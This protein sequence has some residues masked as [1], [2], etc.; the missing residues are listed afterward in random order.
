MSSYYANNT[1]KKS[2]LLK[3]C[4]YLISILQKCIFLKLLCNN[5]KLWERCRNAMFVVEQRCIYIYMCVCACMCVY[6]C[7]C[8]YTH[9]NINTH[10]YIYR[11]RERLF[12]KKNCRCLSA[13]ILSGYLF[14]FNSVLTLCFS[15]LRH[16]K[17]LSVTTVLITP[18][19]LSRCINCGIERVCVPFAW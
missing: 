2:I 18:L 10:I 13:F 12:L 14:Y 16:L 19:W 3:W 7:V 9:I 6:I 15:W 5:A 11:E 8:S 4:F 1:F 17:C